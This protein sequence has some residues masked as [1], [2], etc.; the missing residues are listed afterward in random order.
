MKTYLLTLYAVFCTY[1]YTQNP[2]ELYNNC[3]TPTSQTSLDINNVRTTLLNGGDMWWDLSN[4]GYEVPKNSGLHS[5]FG[6]SLWIGAM[7]ENNQLKVATQM[8]R[9]GGVD[10]WP[11]PLDTDST[12][13]SETCFAYDQHY[14]LLRSEVLAHKYA[15]VGFY[16]RQICYSKLD[17]KL[18]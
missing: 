13:S 14:S 15:F 7:D 9:Q 18:Q 5:I 12:I 11:G 3:A 4:A 1:T 2:V 16:V 17:K 8:F 10:F 6:G